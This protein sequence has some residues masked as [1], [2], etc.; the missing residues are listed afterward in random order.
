MRQKHVSKLTSFEESHEMVGAA[1]DVRRDAAITSVANAMVNQWPAQ[2]LPVFEGDQ[3]QL[4]I[5]EFKT[6]A[7]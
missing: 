2:E 4:F 5:D 7:K 6:M 3:W 1:T